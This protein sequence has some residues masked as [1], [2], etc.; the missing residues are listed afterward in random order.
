[1][2]K[3]LV[4]VLILLVLA[5]VS[6]DIGPSPSFEFSIDN[7]DA[8]SSEYSFYYSGNIWEDRLIKITGDT[9]VYKLNTHIKIFAIPKAIEAQIASYDPSQIDGL[10]GDDKKLVLEN[11]FVSNTFSLPSGKTIYT[12]ASLIPIQKHFL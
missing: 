10:G 2:R 11:S 8:Y 4:T 9:S 5:I 3:I 6:A 1:M 7:Q 12:I